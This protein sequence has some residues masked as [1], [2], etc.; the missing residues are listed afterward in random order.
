MFGKRTMQFFS[1]IKASFN[2]LLFGIKQSK[3]VIL[4]IYA[5]MR[6]PF[7]FLFVKTN[8]FVTR[9][10]RFMKGDVP[11]IFRFGCQS[12]IAPSVVGRIF[13]NVVNLLVGPFTSL[14]SPNN[15]VSTVQFTAYANGNSPFFTMSNASRNISGFAPSRTKNLPYQIAGF[16]V[17]I[18]KIVEFLRC[19]HPQYLPQ[20][21]NF[22]SG[23]Y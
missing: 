17:I 10:V 16:W 4:V 9:C 5:N 23:K 11:H 13:I 2:C 14:H 1:G 12:Q 6:P 3:V 22:A 15:S 7:P 18:K 21:N 8:T 19:D 20:F